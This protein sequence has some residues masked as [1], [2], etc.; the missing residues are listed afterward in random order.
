MCTKPVTAEYIRFLM[1]TQ[2]VTIRQV[3]LACNISQARVR[4]VRAQGGPWDWP[5]MIAHTAQQVAA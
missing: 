5:L 1:R 4:Q 3:S 2:R